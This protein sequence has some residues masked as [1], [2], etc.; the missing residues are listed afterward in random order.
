MAIQFLGSAASQRIT[1]DGEDFEGLV[2]FQN[3]RGS[4]RVVNIRRMLSQLDATATSTSLLVPCL[5]FRGTGE[6]DLTGA[7]RARKCAFDTTKTSDAFVQMWYAVT[8]DWSND[9]G[10]SGTA[11]DVAWRQWA[12]RLRS[13]AEQQQAPDNNQ[14]P[15]LVAQSANKWR[16]YPGEYLLVRVD[17][18][19]LADNKNSNGWFVEC[20]WEEEDLSTFTVSGTV[21]SSGTGVVGAK[22]TVMVADD[23]S[24]TNAYLWKIVTSTSGG[25]WTCEIPAGKM[26]FAY[27]QNYAGSVYYTAAG[28]P[29]IT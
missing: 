18:V 16:L 14:L 29:F 24:L 8:P 28:A 1:G 5:T 6:P 2:I 17:P 26:A 13:A 22:V 10:M 19:A 25:A 23:T 7:C 27:A 4:N 20:V 3:A 21:T 11:G 15:L 12:C 9:S